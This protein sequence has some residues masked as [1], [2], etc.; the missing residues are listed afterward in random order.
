AALKEETGGAVRFAGV[1]G[2]AMQVQGLTSLFPMAELSIMG[3]A[4]VLP[5]L[6][7]LMRRISETAAEATRL[8]PAAVVTIDSPGFNFRLGKKVAGKGIPLI[9]SVAPSVWAWKPG[10]ARKIAQF[11]DHLLALLP[12]EPP[13]FTAVGLPTTFVGHSVIEGGLD[14]GDGPAFRRRHT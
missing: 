7:Q 12:F 14:R 8:K 9:P 13:L 11:L 2:E 6:P 1:G 4:E 5:H 3:L 10:R